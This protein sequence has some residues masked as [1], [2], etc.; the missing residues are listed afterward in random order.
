MGL[1]GQ[2]SAVIR[3]NCS[4]G[5]LALFDRVR[6]CDRGTGSDERLVLNPYV[7]GNFGVG[8]EDLIRLNFFN[9]DSTQ[10]AA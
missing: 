8:G 1:F 7:P 9:R 2:I 6:N 3:L 10:E 4:S 5:R